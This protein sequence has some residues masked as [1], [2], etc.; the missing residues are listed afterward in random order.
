MLIA[1]TL[2]GSH[3]ARFA[4]A[5]TATNIPFA[6]SSETGDGA[7]NL[8]APF[9]FRNWSLHIYPVDPVRGCV[10]VIFST[11]SGRRGNEP[12]VRYSLMFSSFSLDHSESDAAWSGHSYGETGGAKS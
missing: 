2:F 12:A 5:S 11:R 10:P 7:M 6:S 8:A 4:S 1:A 9:R 3:L